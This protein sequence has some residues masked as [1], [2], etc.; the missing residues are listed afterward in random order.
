MAYQH[1]IF[2]SYRRNPET[3]VWITEHFVPL[4]EMRVEFELG[5][6]PKIYVD[7]RSKAA[8]PGLPR[9][10]RA[11]RVARSDTAVERQLP[12]ERVVH[13]GT[14]PHARAREE[15]AGLR[16]ANDRT[17]SSFRVPSTMTGTDSPRP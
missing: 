17:A 14:E 15:D 7:I 11:R 10:D 16:T 4:L 5:R 1:D 8:R 2:I 13:R 3:C 12:V 9:R 6:K